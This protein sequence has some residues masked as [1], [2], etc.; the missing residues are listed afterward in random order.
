MSKKPK[1]TRM[2]FFIVLLTVLLLGI[3][4]S[5][6]GNSRGIISISPALTYAFAI[7]AVLLII[8][9]LIRI[10]LVPRFRIVPGRFQAFLES[11]TSLISAVAKKIRSIWSG[12]L[13]TLNKLLGGEEMSRRTKIKSLCLFIVILAVLLVGIILTGGGALLRGLD[14]LIEE[15]LNIP[16][17]IADTPID[18]AADG[19]GVCLEKKL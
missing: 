4:L 10:F 5:G 6:I 7:T 3:I 13:R 14:T 1:R 17:E 8:A 15:E 18:C 19:I 12:L 11:V 2:W 9:A 16:V